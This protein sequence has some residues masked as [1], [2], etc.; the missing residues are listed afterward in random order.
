[1]KTAD[2]AQAKYFLNENKRVII[3]GLIENW[4]FLLQGIFLQGDGSR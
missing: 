1:M 3:D 2:A 4:I